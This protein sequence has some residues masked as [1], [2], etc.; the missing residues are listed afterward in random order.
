MFNVVRIS[1]IILKQNIQISLLIIKNVR[2]YDY[3][4]S[5]NINNIK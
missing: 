2:L 4:Y 5:H 3:D 1:Y